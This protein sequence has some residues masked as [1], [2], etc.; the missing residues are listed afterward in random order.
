MNRRKNPANSPVTVLVILLSFQCTEL[1]TKQSLTQTLYHK[2]Y[3]QIARSRLERGKRPPNACIFRRAFETGY[4][5][6]EL[7]AEIQRF[8]TDH[9]RR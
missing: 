4:I 5:S 7:R 2:G 9:I 1:L 6:N 8:L 3:K